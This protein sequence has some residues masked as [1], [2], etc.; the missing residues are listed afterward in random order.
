MDHS[1]ERKEL[2]RRVAGWITSPWKHVTINPSDIHDLVDQRKECTV[3]D[4]SFEDTSKEQFVLHYSLPLSDE[5][6]SEDDNYGHL[7][8]HAIYAEIKTF[9]SSTSVQFSRRSRTTI[10]K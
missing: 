6:L 2:R 10:Q 7:Q 3:V 9:V 1:A 5:T 4:F 8:Y